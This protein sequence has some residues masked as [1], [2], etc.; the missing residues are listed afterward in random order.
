[1]LRE[2]NSKFG[3]YFRIRAELPMCYKLTDQARDVFLRILMLYALVFE[4]QT[5][6]K[7]KTRSQ[8]MWVSLCQVIFLSAASYARIGNPRLVHILLNYLVSSICG[9][10]LCVFM[11]ILST[12]SWL[13]VTPILCLYRYTMLRETMGQI[14]YPII[15]TNRQTVIF[16]DREYVCRYE[17]KELQKKIELLNNHHS[18]YW[19]SN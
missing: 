12:F 17:G 18:N 9:L 6:Q 15:P 7:D 16:P 11:C 5:A 1:M 19:F 13:Y 14:R 4:V 2:D 3:I 8:L 10:D